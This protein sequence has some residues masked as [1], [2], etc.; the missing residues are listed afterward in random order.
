MRLKILYEIL[1]VFFCE[2]EQGLSEKNPDYPRKKNI[3]NHYKMSAPVKPTPIA[4]LT[5]RVTSLTAQVSNLPVSFVTSPTVYDVATQAADAV[6]YALAHPTHLVLLEPAAGGSTISSA[7]LADANNIF[8]WCNVADSPA[9]GTSIPNIVFEDD[10]S[11]VLYTIGPGET[12]TAIYVAAAA[13]WILLP[14]CVRFATSGATTTTTT[15]T[16][17]AAPTTEEPT[18]TV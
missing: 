16:T 17:T 10:V 13:K 2:R 18:T 9:A 8:Y 6:T 11:T 7:D 12:A 1:I 3:S 4:N 15:T 5:Y 14:G